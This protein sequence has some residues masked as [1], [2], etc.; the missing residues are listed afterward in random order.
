MTQYAKVLNG[1]VIQVIEAEPTFIEKFRDSS[2]GSWI[3]AE[4]SP[5]HG[6]RG[7][8]PSPGY[9]Y[10]SVNQVFI[11]PKPST[12]AILNTSTW[13]WSDPSFSIKG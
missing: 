7:N 1:Q 11:P 8:W 5:G 2:P 6:A 9:S 10:D 13:H 12:T 3:S 4:S